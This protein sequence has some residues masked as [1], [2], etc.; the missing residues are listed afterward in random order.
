VGIVSHEFLAVKRIRTDLRR[1]VGVEV[2]D[3]HL[4]SVA[5]EGRSMDD[6]LYGCRASLW[7]EARREGGRRGVAAGGVKQF[8]GGGPHDRSR[9]ENPGAEGFG[10]DIRTQHLLRKATRFMCPTNP[11]PARRYPTIDQ[12]ALGNVLRVTT[13]AHSSCRCPLG[14]VNHWGRVRADSSRP[15]M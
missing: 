8:S 6:L 5:M 14:N 1:K 12:S 11:S 10:Y 7:G 3:G 4:G 13:T 2:G 15:Y 9:P